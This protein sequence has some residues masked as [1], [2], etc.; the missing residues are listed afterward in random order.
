MPE[1]LHQSTISS[2]SSPLRDPITT[3]PGDIPFAD[4]AARIATQRTQFRHDNI[5]IP[6]VP[7]AGQTVEIWATSG[8]EIPLRQAILYYTTDGSLPDQSA[9]ALPM[10]QVRTDWD[11]LAGYVTRWRTTVPA[12][13]AQTVVRYRIGGWKKDSGPHIAAQPDVW[14][15][16][17]QGFLFR[18]SGS[19]AITTF[20]Y[21]VEESEPRLPAWARDAIIYQIFLDRFRTSA[22][23]GTFPEGL[24]RTQIHG[25]TLQGVI[26]GLPYLADL[27]VNCLWLSPI[28]P[29]ETY[30]RYDATDF[31][32]V[33]PVLGTLEDLKRLTDQAH[34]LG[35]R[36]LLDFV[37]SH[38][39][40]HHPAFLVAQQ[41]QHA[42]SYEWFTFK[43]WPDQY[44]SFLD[45]VPSLPSLNTANDGARTYVIE[46]ALQ[47][48]RDYGIDGFRL[49]H[50]IGHGMDFWTAFRH[51]TRA[52]VPDVISVAEA[53]DTPDSLARY[54]GKLDGILDFPLASA[55]RH[56]F[57]SQNWSVEKFDH[58]LY[59][60][61]QFMTQGPGRVSFLDN[62][63]MDRFLFVAGNDKRRLK[64]AALCQFT[65]S[66]VPV[67]YYGTEVGMS[68]QHEV[69]NRAA[70]G[71]SQAR[72]DMIWDPQQ[73]DQDLLAFYRSLIRL[74][75]EAPALRQG[76][77]RTLHVS[78]AHGTYVYVR[79]NSGE[80]EKYVPGDVLVILNLSD[81]VRRLVLP[82][83]LVPEQYQ[84]LLETG[85][86]PLDIQATALG[87][88]IVVAPYGGATLI[89][90]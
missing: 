53:T 42:P 86:Q 46:S 75:Q 12:Q 43:H 25:G 59:A 32:T 81:Q 1:G 2:P 37:P 89:A 23:D 13:A 64:L 48:L 85:A 24:K 8:E 60:Y 66:A 31:F 79:S 28:T 11:L 45:N 30:H 56:A 58:F 65:L 76:E 72:E 63:D 88:E 18:L 69:A 15:Q 54:Y 38:I 17:G 55:F 35:M 7:L 68:Q 70:G 51:A 5:L 39:S 33:D 84:V 67:I 20:A 77:R 4:I 74:R 41:D 9:A 62:H 40:W 3:A 16:D 50:A 83:S 78:A 87:R 90:R 73:W 27:G 71:D 49:D 44:R 80:T 47:W 36:V 21:T 10:E 19:D 82:D 34:A 61:E 57:G 14:A 52:A 6:A 22:P 29:A 26:D